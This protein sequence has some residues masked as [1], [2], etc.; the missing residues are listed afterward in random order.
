MKEQGCLVECPY[1]KYIRPDLQGK[2]T[3]PKCHG[4]TTYFQ[5]AQMMDK[6]SAAKVLLSELWVNLDQMGENEQQ[7]FLL[8]WL[9]RIDIYQFNLKDAIIYRLKDLE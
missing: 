2:S 7:E 5:S 1:C 3:C 4:N 9:K 6:P 8:N